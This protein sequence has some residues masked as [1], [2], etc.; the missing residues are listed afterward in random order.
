M[1]KKFVF[2]TNDTSQFLSHRGHLLKILYNLNFQTYIFAPKYNDV[3]K[4]FMFGTLNMIL[5][6]KSFVLFELIKF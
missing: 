4:N 3:F 6:E 5:V 1:K 2:F